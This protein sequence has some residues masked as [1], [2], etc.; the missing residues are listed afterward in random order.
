MSGD[1]GVDAKEH[2]RGRHKSSPMAAEQKGRTG[3]D[4]TVKIAFAAC[5]WWAEGWW[6]R[7]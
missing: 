5:W 4:E 7:V 2:D 3:G 1:Q 6:P